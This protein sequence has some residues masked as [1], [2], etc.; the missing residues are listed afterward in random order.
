MVLRIIG[1]ITFLRS[2]NMSTRIRRKNPATMKKPP[3][4]LSI[5]DP[6][7]KAIPQKRKIRKN[8]PNTN[9]ATPMATPEAAVE[10][11]CVTLAFV[12]CM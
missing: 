12:S 11:L 3:A 8:R 6:S 1:T 9:A 10:A 7:H 2:A 5:N 4:R